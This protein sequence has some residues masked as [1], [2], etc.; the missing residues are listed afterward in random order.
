M[1]YFSAWKNRKVER[2]V[3]DFVGSERGAIMVSVDN[4]F[5]TIQYDPEHRRFRAI[6]TN[7][8]MNSDVFSMVQSESDV[9]DWERPFIN[10]YTTDEAQ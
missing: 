7:S 4:D 10:T 9:N 5:W 1:S 3:F 8:D 2:K 6:R